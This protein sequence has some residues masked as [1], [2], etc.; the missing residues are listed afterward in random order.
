M[1]TVL[2]LSN[3]ITESATDVFP[4]IVYIPVRLRLQFSSNCANRLCAANRIA[5][6]CLGF[7]GREARPPQRFYRHPPDKA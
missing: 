6:D 7:P 5:I 2:A 4:A 3:T 1:Y